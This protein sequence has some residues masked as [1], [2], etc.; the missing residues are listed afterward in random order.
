MSGSDPAVFGV[1]RTRS[2]RREKD[3]EVREERVCRKQEVWQL[4]SSP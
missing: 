2:D 4:A 3:S 1:V